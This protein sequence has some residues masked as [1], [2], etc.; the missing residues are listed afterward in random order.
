VLFISG[1]TDGM[2]QSHGLTPHTSRLLVKPFTAVT[3]LQA[4]AEALA[5]DPLG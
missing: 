3:L 4:V 2:L 5:G 1:Y